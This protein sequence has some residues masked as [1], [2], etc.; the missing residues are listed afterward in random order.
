M[1]TASQLKQQTNRTRQ[2]KDR[3]LSAPSRCDEHNHIHDIKDQLPKKN[4]ID[5]PGLHS[6]RE[7]FPVGRDG[8]PEKQ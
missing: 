3:P 8:E 4:P 1:P 7:G 6:D 2:D 5:V